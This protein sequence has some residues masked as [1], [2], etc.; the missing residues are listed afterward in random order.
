L[1]S[2]KQIDLCMALFVVIDSYV[3]RYAFC[4]PDDIYMFHCIDVTLNIKYILWDAY[5]MLAE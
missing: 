4:Y 3:I 2:H 1:I 5:Y